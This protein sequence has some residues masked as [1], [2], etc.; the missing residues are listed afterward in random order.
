MKNGHF[1]GIYGIPHL[2]IDPNHPK[3]WHFVAIQV[4]SMLA[5]ETKSP[6]QTAEGHEIHEFD[7]PLS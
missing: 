6:A 1:M 2:Q 4:V 5:A 3:S 7:S